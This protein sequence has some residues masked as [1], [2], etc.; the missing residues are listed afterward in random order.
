[1]GHALSRGSARADAVSRGN[2]D[3][4]HQPRLL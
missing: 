3:G 1:M 4:R 2:T